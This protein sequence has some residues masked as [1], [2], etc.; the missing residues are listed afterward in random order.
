MEYREPHGRDDGELAKPREV[1]VSSL[2]LEAAE[3]NRPSRQLTWT[4]NSTASIEDER[5]QN[6]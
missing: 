5:K 3:S 6:G 1:L 2:Q 4:F